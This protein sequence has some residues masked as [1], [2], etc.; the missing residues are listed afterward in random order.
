MKKILLFLSLTSSLFAQTNGAPPSGPVMSYRLLGGNDAWQYGTIPMYAYPQNGGL[1]II[2]PSNLSDTGSQILY[3][4]AP[5]SVS[6]GV[7][8]VNGAQGTIQFI[9]GAQIAIT[10]TGTGQFTV[11]FSGG[12]FFPQLTTWNVATTYNTGDIVLY[13]GVVYTS[14]S[15]GNTATLPTNTG[16]WAKGVPTSSVTIPATNLVLVGTNVAGASRAGT[17]GTDYVI[18][19]GLV[20]TATA[21]ATTPSRCGSGYAPTGVDVSGNALECTPIGG[22]AQIP[23][24]SFVLVGTGTIGVS[25]AGT[26]GVDYLAPNGSA[27]AL[28]N[29]PIFNQDTTGR[30][31]LAVRFVSVPSGCSLGY[32]PQSVDVSGNAIGC[33]PVTGGVGS[34]VVG[35]GARAEAVVYGTSTQ[36]VQPNP[37]LFELDNGMSLSDINAA[38]SAASS[39]G[40]SVII[41]SGVGQQQFTNSSGFIVD[42]HQ[43]MGWTSL[44]S[45][46][47]VCDGRNSALTISITSG[48]NTSSVGSLFSSLDEGKTF[49]FTSRSGYALG[50]TQNVWTP[51]LLS[52]AYPTATWTSNA[53]F[54]DNALIPYG[55]DN[56]TAVNAIMAATSAVFPFTLPTGCQLLVN[57]TVLWNNSQVIVGRHQA[58][59]GFLGKP[60]TDVI[61]TVSSSGNSVS[62]VG[63]GLKGFSIQNATEIDATLGFN[64]F[65][66]NG[67]LTVVPPVYRP[68]YDHSDSAPVP[69]APG[70]VTGGAYGVST[71][72]Q[73]SAVLCT[74]NT[75][76]SPVVG[77]QIMFPYFASIFISTVSSTAGSCSSGFTARTMAGAFPNT[78]TYNVT[79]AEWITGS[80]FQSTTTTIPTTITY[81]I[82][83]ALTLSTDPIAGWLSNFPQHGHIKLC[84][85][86]FDYL[87]INQYSMTLQKGPTTSAGC[88]GTTPM[89]VMNMCA[90]KNLFGSSTDQPWPVIPSINAGDSTPSG[91]NWFPGQCGG[92][93]GI[94][95]PTPNGNTY[96]GSGLSGGFLSD[97]FIYG[98]G[99]NSTQNANN[100]GAILIQGNN[101]FFS[102]HVNNITTSALQYSIVQGPAS[103]GQHGV[104]AVGPT[105]IGNSFRDLWLFGAFGLSLVDMQ[106][107]TFENLNMNSTEINPFDGTPIGSATCVHIGYTLDEQTGYVVTST[108]YLNLRP[109]ACE[110]ENGSHKEVLAAVDIEGS[111]VGFD[112]T[113]FEGIPSVFGGDHL[114]IQDNSMAFPIRNYGYSNDFGTLIGNPMPYL[115]NVW[116]SSSAQLYDWG[117]A[118]RCLIVSGG[119]LPIPCVNFGRSNTEPVR[120]TP[121]MWDNNGA[122]DHQPMSTIGTVDITAPYWGSSATCNLGGSAACQV[123]EFYGL[124]GYMFIGQWNQLAPQPYVLDA[125]FKSKNAPSSF[126]LQ[127][128]VLD[129]GFGTCNTGGFT[130]ISTTTVNT[131]TSFSPAPASVIDLSNSK[132]CTFSVQMYQGST[133][134]TISVDKFNLV[135]ASLFT[136]GPVTAPTYPGSCPVGTQASSYLG[137]F[138]GYSYFCDGGTVHRNAVI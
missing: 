126:S 81:P 63:T 11:A 98:S 104:A 138:S 114:K 84:G 30:S 10:N 47:A 16:F 48:S 46:G 21:L 102:S 135:P 87:G 115:T 53:P 49:F 97:L 7:Q 125:T 86:E 94:A 6:A 41:P 110:P 19:S 132:G 85:Q 93:F 12:G 88:T 33:A 15:N 28:T 8:S 13:V 83:L 80:A 90:A 68:L 25:K 59:G 101:A 2:G 42:M 44:M 51:K 40:G 39:V 50:S 91:A 32:A 24:T 58:S 31:A 78:S 22:A 62:G 66:A 117:T 23:A 1:P 96:V 75:Y 95:F 69:F 35:N 133:T 4:G 107:S 61:S 129:S 123:Q 77:Q 134:D 99:Q 57:G 124:S 73:N 67:T 56:L 112:G 106:S 34:G 72:S 70:W 119:G 14:T 122:F 89:A 100:A 131:T 20:A 127:I 3:K 43:Y 26:P 103:A 128:S 65:D 108:Q 38:M 113:N 118:T 137:T 71:I 76:A 36:T 64:S 105:G 74:N 121:G 9:P 130:V 79:Q 5:I 82:T 54:S 52:Y 109:Q 136:R 116:N 92:N 60:G 27:A 120:I 45:K 111:H 17:P 18:P 29:F 37:T 55:T